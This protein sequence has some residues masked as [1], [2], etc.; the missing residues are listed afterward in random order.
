MKNV[1]LDDF[2][3]DRIQENKELFTEE[4]LKSIKNDKGCI[5]KMYLLGF[6]HGKECYEKLD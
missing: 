4:E 5:R 2:I 3:E 1:R 6:I